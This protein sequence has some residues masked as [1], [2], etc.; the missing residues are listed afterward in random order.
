VTIL[1][2]NCDA[3]IRC[4]FNEFAS[5]INAHNFFSSST[6]ESILVLNEHQ[7]D[8]V[9]LKIGKLTDLS[10][11][12]YIDDYY[13]DIEVLVC[14]SENF[15]EALTIFTQVHFKKIKNPMRLSDLKEHLV[16]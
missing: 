9:V 5:E 15:D 13:K 4:E 8:K 2:I 11:M 7:I 12:K 6:E 10:I 14:A 1:F 16:H 3:S